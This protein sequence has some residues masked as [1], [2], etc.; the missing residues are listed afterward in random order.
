MGKANEKEARAWDEQVA[1]VP[2]KLLCEAHRCDTFYGVNLD[3]WMLEVRPQ[4]TVLTAAA[5]T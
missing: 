5:D 3:E 4:R 2:I 1:D